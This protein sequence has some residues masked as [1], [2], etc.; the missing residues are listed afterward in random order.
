M[1]VVK[2]LPD[3]A[4]TLAVWTVCGLAT[5]LQ[6]SDLTEKQIRKLRAHD[7]ISGV[8]KALYTYRTLFVT[9]ARELF[10][11]GPEVYLFSKEKEL[12]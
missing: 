7:V 2:F 10:R 4:K 1:A 11:R 9:E 5:I 3:D 12:D 6:R 8:A